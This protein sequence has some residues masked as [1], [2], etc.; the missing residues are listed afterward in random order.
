MKEYIKP[1]VIK[2]DIANTKTGGTAG[3]GENTTYSPS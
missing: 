1:V 2:L 3:I